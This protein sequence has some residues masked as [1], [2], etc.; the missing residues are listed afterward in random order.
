M[1]FEWSGVN[2]H[3][4]VSGIRRIENNRLKITD[5][6]TDTDK[7][8]QGLGWGRGGGQTFF[9]NHILTVMPISPLLRVCS[10]AP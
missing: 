5:C 9:E 6:K 3:L 7:E 4:K 10:P 8:G 2:G 1:V